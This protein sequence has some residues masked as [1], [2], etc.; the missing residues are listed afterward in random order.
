MLEHMV[1]KADQLVYEMVLE[2]DRV[3]YW[4]HAPEFQAK[5]PW[6]TLTFYLATDPWVCVAPLIDP[7]ESGKCLGEMTRDHSHSHTGGTKGKRAPTTM[8]TL[9]IFCQHHHLWT[10]WVT[11]HR[12]QIRTYI[13]E[14]N[15][16]YRGITG[17]SQS[18]P[19]RPE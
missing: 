16:R 5:N 14:A 19:S 13:K 11:S 18:Q 8:K 7:S 4:A 10:H 1:S 6:A 12:D 9:A 17:R 15:E 3:M 2:R